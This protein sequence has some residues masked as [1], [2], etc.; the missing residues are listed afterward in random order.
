MLNRRHTRPVRV[1]DVVIGGS[2]AIVVQSMTKVPTTQVDRCLGQILELVQAGCRL[3][4]VAVPTRPDTQALTKIVRQS[5]VPIIADVHFSAQ[6][7]I[8]AIEAG[9]AKVRINPGNMEKK[10]IARIVDAA[11]MNR[12]AMRIGVNEASIRDLDHDTPVED[13]IRLMIERIRDYVTLIESRGMDQLVLSAKSSDPVRT[14]LTNRAIADAFDHPIHLG[15]THAGLPEDAVI[16]SSVTLGTL[17]AEGI[18]DT[19]R[20][21]LAGDPVEEVRMAYAILRSLGLSAQPRPELVVC[22]TCGRTQIDLIGL[23]RHVRQAL[24]AVKKPLRVAVM[25]CVVNGP[26]EA[27]DADIAVC[28][29]K[30]KAFIYRKGTKVAVVPE[31]QVCNALLEVIQQYCSAS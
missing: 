4:R 14:I 10:E 31:D 25:G 17:L 15:L 3:V 27:A 22:P 5:G 2:S 23:A 9:V 26:G 24:Q 12:V 13:R 29:G 28:G 1:G 6:R 16:G 20:V 8:E 7:A 19:I 21:S 11:K 18:G 30:G